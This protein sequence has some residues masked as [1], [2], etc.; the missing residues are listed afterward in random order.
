MT[1]KPLMVL[2]GHPVLE[3]QPAIDIATGRLL[4]FEALVRW[5]HPTK[6]HIPPKVLIPWAEANDDIVSLNAWVIA[7][8][9]NTAQGWPSGIQMAVNCSIAQLRQGE[10]S[11]AVATALETSGLNP[12]RLSIEVTEH[13][14]ADDDAAAELRSLVALGVHLAV[15]DVGTSW[16]SLQPLRRFAVETVKIDEAFV[17]NLEAE[18]GMNRAIV[19]AVIHVSHSLAMSTVAEGVETAQQVATLREFGADVAQGFFFSPPLANEEADELAKRDP[20]PVFTLEP[21]PEHLGPVGAGVQAKPLSIVAPVGRA[22]S[23]TPQA[24]SS[25]EVQDDASGA[26]PKPARPRQHAGK[27]AHLSPKPTDTAGAPDESS[28]AG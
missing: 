5:D 12:D 14:I 19:E 6:G 4:G 18:E 20:R 2:E 16:S 15:D 9:C 24:G 3:Y 28:Q 26:T 11:K 25:P 17:A 27:P 1:D 21:G 22:R 13:A 7:E 10:A 23:K 8:A